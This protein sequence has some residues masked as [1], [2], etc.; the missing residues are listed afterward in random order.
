MNY[1][2]EPTRTTRWIVELRY[3]AWQDCE[4]CEGTG[5]CAVHG[6]D[7]YQC[8][9]CNGEGGVWHEAIWYNPNTKEW[10]VNTCTHSIAAVTKSSILILSGEVCKECDGTGVKCAR[11]ETLGLDYVHCKVCSRTGIEPGTA[12]EWRVQP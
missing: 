10:L 11:H 4:A 9:A 8:G 12:G 1:T 3:P 6:I 5:D 2:L 7:P